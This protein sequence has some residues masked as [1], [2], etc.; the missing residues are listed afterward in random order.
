MTT[1]LITYYD[2]GDALRRV[3]I[4]ADSAP[5][6]ERI[7]L[8][9]E[10]GQYCPFQIMDTAALPSAV[11]AGPAWTEELAPADPGGESTDWD[12]CVFDLADL[13]VG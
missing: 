8:D 1:Y 6:A 2:L 7:L 3:K 5:Q 9:D 12:A 10:R 4:E 13:G 11:Q